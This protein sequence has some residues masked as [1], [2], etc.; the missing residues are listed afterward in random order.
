MKSGI[1]EKYKYQKII[2]KIELPSAKTGRFS[3]PNKNNTDV[4]LVICLC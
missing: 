2:N 4:I 3:S 1:E